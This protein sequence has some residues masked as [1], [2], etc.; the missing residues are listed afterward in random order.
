MDEAY[1]K[2]ALWLNDCGK[3]ATFI[4]SIATLIDPQELMWGNWPFLLQ[5]ILGL[6]KNMKII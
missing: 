6:K 3:E 2:V 4:I 1:Y 5:K